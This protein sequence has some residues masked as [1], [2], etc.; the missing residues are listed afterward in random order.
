MIILILLSFFTI[1]YIWLVYVLIISS[2]MPKYDKNF[3]QPVS[4]IIPCY[5]EDPVYLKRCI[6]SILNCNGEKQVILVN[7]NS[8][9]LETIQALNEL[10]SNRKILI[11]TE[12]R[13]GKR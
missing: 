4:V 9:K 10:K 6:E 1:F 3:R 7:N 13:Q 5:N 11:I 8:N 12:K 2:K